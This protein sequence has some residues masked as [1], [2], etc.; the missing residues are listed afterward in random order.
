MV[1]HVDHTHPG[2]MFLQLGQ[3][4]KRP[5]ALIGMAG[6]HQFLQRHAGKSMESA[7]RPTW[8]QILPLSPT[9]CVTGAK[10]LFSLTEAPRL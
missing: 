8:I 10:H 6:G 5:A 4:E 3:D 7:G 2:P 9:T 1:F